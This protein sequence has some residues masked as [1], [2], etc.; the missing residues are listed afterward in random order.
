MNL[1]DKTQEIKKELSELNQSLKMTLER[2][3]RVGKLL[4]EQKEFIGHGL[5]VSWV[6]SNLDISWDTT[7][8]YIKCFEHHDKISNLPNLQ[9]AY[10]QIENIEQQA[11]QSKEQR[12]REMISEYRKTGIKPAG[13]DRSIDYRIKKDDEARKAQ[14]DRIERERI[15]REN[16]AKDRKES[17]TESTHHTV[18]SEALKTA[19]ETIIGKMEKR[20]EWK[21]KIRLSDNGKEPFMDAIIDYLEGLESDS[22]RI[23]ACNNIIKICRNIA[24][25]LQRKAA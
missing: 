2:A 18:F 8:R 15:A 19:T 5:F 17:Q 4:C 6:E 24:V 22:R 10:K 23:E 25:E 1:T 21:E 12:D 7:N 9:D 11:R 13:W 3:I 16:R 20:E 14:S